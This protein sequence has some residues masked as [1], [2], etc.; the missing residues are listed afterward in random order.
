MHIISL[1][2][3]FFNKLVEQIWS[4][5]LICGLIYFV[6]PENGFCLWFFILIIEIR[7][8]WECLIFPHYHETDHYD[9]KIK[10]S[11]KA[12][13]T[14]GMIWPQ[15]LLNP[16]G[17][18]CSWKGYS[19]LHIVTHWVALGVRDPLSQSLITKFWSSLWFFYWFLENFCI[20]E[21][22][23]MTPQMQN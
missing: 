14:V 19:C 11:F 1:V 23:L 4:A 21:V 12:S 13:G 8:V 5:C 20:F 7:H 3:G 2:L 6:N 17:D 10:I 15:K 9:L 18:I 16:V 22:L